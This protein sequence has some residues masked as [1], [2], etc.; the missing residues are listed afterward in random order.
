MI[1]LLVHDLGGL[2]LLLPLGMPLLF[3]LAFGVWV[4]R[5]A[6]AR[7]MDG[8]VWLLIL[9]VSGPLGLILYF[10]LRKPSRGLTLNRFPYRYKHLFIPLGIIV[11]IVPF[12][13]YLWQWTQPRDRIGGNTLPHLLNVIGIFLILYGLILYHDTRQVR[14]EVI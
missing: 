10:V 3:G 2:E 11:N 12:L 7:G 5:D 13:P 4:Y 14:S 6:E 1:Q 9:L 8:A